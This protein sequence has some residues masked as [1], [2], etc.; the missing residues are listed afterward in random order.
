MRLYIGCRQKDW[1]VKF[2]FCVPKAK[3]ACD[4]DFCGSKNALFNTKKVIK[5]F[6]LFILTKHAHNCKRNIYFSTLSFF[7]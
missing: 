2:I 5:S 3:A 4:R 7:F 1:F 6:I